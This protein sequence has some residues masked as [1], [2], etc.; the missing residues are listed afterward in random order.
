MTPLKPAEALRDQSTV[1][2]TDEASDTVVQKI[3]PLIAHVESLYETDKNAKLNDETRALKAYRNYRGIY[4]PDVVFM[5]TEKSRAFIKITKT[6]VMASFGQE[7]EALFNNG[8]LPLEI[9]PS[10]ETLG[11]PELAHV[12]PN[13]PA[14][15][16]PPG[17]PSEG[18]LGFPGDGNDL[19]PGETLGDRV[20]NW[21]KKKFGNLPVKLKL[22]A[23]NS[24]QDITFT[25]AKDAALKMNK[26]I[27]DQLEE[28]QA[29]VE[30]KK[31]AFEKNLLG[32]GILLGPFNISK[33]YPDWD[34]QGEY[35]P[36]KAEI[37]DLRHCSFWDFYPDSQASRQKDMGHFTIVS[38]ASRAT[39][40][41]L[42]DDPSF[43]SDAIERLL[44]LG[45]N[46]EERWFEN[47]LNDN[48]SQTDK[49]S[50]YFVKTFWGSIDKSVIEASGLSFGFPLPEDIKE[51]DCNIWWSGT[52]IIRLVL[53]PYKPKRLPVYIC[54]HEEHPYSIFG[55]GVAENMEDTQML[56]NGFIRLAVDNAVLSGCVMLEVDGTMLEPGQ[57]MKISSGKIFYKSSGPPGAQAIRS[58]QIANTSPANIQLF[59]TMRRLADEATGIPSF[60]HGMT[61]VQGV[62]RTASGI[63]QLLGAASLTTKT[64]LKNDDDYWFTP[65]GNAWYCWNMQFKFDKSLRG[66]LSVVA[67]GL[68][69]L[70]QKE[71]KL[72]KLIQ[73]GQIAASIPY[74]AA[75]QKW[76]QWLR[77]IYLSAELDADQMLNSPE[78]AAVQGK[79]MQLMAAIDAQKQ[80]ASGP[81]GVPMDNQQPGQGPPAQ[82]G[83]QGFPASGG[84]QVMQSRGGIGANNASP[85][86]TQEA[87]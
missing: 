11:F 7:C 8:K 26:R 31:A 4:G 53:N 74:A 29:I 15:T 32:T 66:D 48:K 78:E 1:A 20:K 86:N 65:I 17:M 6:K 56:M 67:R 73:V 24:P 60:S 72:Q 62:G 52:E 33:E 49:R 30:F 40:R 87:A 79:L 69:N 35:I 84:A 61:G 5:D 36:T 57:Q 3:L 75:Y 80:Q 44:A 13:D 46:Y 85:G 54:P 41:S 38:K 83:Q 68:S 9:V 70:M 2:L 16:A 18:V 64:V 22:G 37:P 50:R 21:A 14:D 76:R 42:Q 43:R 63:S 19:S 59:D 34:E 39:L 51:V 10:P 27:H 45:P 58:I 77:E 23:G 55:I 71:I 47:Y 25:P 82:P 81:G 12:D 28:S